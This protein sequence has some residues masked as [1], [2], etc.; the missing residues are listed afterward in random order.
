VP[1]PTIGCV[2][3]DGPVA[4]PPL[5]A[6]AL[7]GALV[8][9]G[10]IWHDIR[11]VAETGSTNADLL[12]LAPGGA[13]EGVLL[14]AEAQSA[15]RGRMG[16]HWVSP[17]RAALMFS[18]LL[19]PAG[20]PAA[21]RGWVPLLTGVAVAS[22]LSAQAAIDARL[23]WPND[24]LVNG[25]KLA[26]ILAEQS[27]DA[28]VVGTGINVSASRDELPG[29]AATSL[30]LEGAACT[31]R[32]LLLAR[33][34]TELEFWYLA[35]VGARGDASGCGLRQEYQRRCATL[36]RQVRVSLPGGT[37]VTGTASEVDDTGRLV[38]R[39]A[40]ESVPVSAGDVIHVR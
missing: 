9:P 6:H 23:K 1:G 25:A 18:V 21:L 28:I 26:G 4:R 19:R 38:V 7:R 12:A 36:G 14:A 29:P 33:V 37:V 20:V 10:S 15:G 11:V 17:P 8:K 27:G 35:W 39:S 13:G 40:A 34:L 30:T 22:A 2:T 5:N 3:I 31:D 24:V 32:D 16:R